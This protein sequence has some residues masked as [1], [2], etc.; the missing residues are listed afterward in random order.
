MNCAAIK[1]RISKDTA[2]SVIN[3]RVA[4]S[5]RAPKGP[6]EPTLTD[7]VGEVSSQQSDARRAFR[8]MVMS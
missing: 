8:D 1:S 6:H 4:N 7:D 2:M 3:S 5:A